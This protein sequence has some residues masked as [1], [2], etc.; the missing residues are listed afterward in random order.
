MQYS[1]TVF[2]MVLTFMGKKQDQRTYML[3]SLCL[4]SRTN[5]ESINL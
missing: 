5:D 3:F 2:T 4:V 1:S